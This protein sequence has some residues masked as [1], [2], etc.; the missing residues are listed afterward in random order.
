MLH[1]NSLALIIILI[2]LRFVFLIVLII[3]RFIILIVRSSVFILRYIILIVLIL[4]S[5]VFRPNS[6]VR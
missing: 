1:S 5:I 2:I 6:R 3:L 4:H